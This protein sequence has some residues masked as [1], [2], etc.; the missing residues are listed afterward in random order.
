VPADLDAAQLVLS[1]LCLVLGP[2]V[3]PQL[4]R[5]VTGCSATSKQQRDRRATFLDALEPR[6]RAAL[7]RAST[8]D[9]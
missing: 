5:L 8:T 2:L 1:E 9:E 4:T 6:L 3:L 7:T